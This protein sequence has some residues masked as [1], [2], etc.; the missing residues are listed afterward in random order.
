MRSFDGAD[1]TH[2]NFQGWGFGTTGGVVTDLMM[3]W[4]SFA[5]AISSFELDQHLQDKAWANYKGILSRAAVDQGS[6]AA[7]P[8]ILQ[9]LEPAQLLCS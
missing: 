1:H 5:V 4:L 6:N 7:H 8:L 3:A 9:A 2:N